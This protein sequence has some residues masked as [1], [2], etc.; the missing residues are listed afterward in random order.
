MLPRWRLHMRRNVSGFG[1]GTI[2]SRCML[3]ALLVREQ[4]LNAHSHQFY[5][6]DCCK[7]IAFC[8]PARLRH[9][10]PWDC[11]CCPVLSPAEIFWQSAYSLC[12]PWLSFPMPRP[13]NNALTTNLMHESPARALVNRCVKLRLELARCFTTWFQAGGRRIA[14]RQ[15]ESLQT[16][17][18]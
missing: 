11:C 9:P 8:F 12:C 16:R 4:L 3:A 1:E 2:G 10:L 14:S 18:Q 17:T 13:Q 6:G 5:P 15:E 7:K